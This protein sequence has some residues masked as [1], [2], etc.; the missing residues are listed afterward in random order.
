M[1]CPKCGGEK[2]MLAGMTTYRCYNCGYV[3]STEESAK[4][5]ELILPNNNKGNYELNPR[6]MEVYDVLAKKLII[7]GLQATD[8]KITIAGAE[9]QDSNQNSF[10]KMLILG[11]YNYT[12][13]ISKDLLKIAVKEATQKERE[14]WANKLLSDTKE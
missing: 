14:Y 1:N 2:L 13:E 10:Y 3:G 12:A 11:G 6:E 9:V 8:I 4:K 5:L 7:A